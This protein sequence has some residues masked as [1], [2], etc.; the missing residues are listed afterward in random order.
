MLM[1]VH[2]PYNSSNGLHFN[3]IAKTT[4]SFSQISGILEASSNRSDWNKL[5]HK[6]WLVFKEV[7][8]LRV[9]GGGTING[10]GKIWWENSCKINKLLVSTFKSP[11]SIQPAN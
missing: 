1:M 9:E 11:L 2:H 3:R 7:D 10:N 5:D 8:Y 4:V 6:H